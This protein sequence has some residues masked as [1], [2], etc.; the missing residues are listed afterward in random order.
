MPRRRRDHSDAAITLGTMSSGNVRSWPDN[1]KVMPWSA[2]ARSSASERAVR[3]AAAV[4]AMASCSARYGARIPPSAANISSKASWCCRSGW[5]Y[6]S[7]NAASPLLAAALL[8]DWDLAVPVRPA[9]VLAGRFTERLTVVILTEYGAVG[10]ALRTSCRYVWVTATAPTSPARLSVRL[11][12]AWRM[13]RVGS[14]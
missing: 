9:R 12:A 5:K 2:Y 3:S 11:S 6:P 8:S 13:G 1:E 7:N 10:Y 14:S 4:G